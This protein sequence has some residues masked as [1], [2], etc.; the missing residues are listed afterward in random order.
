MTEGGMRYLY[1]AINLACCTVLAVAFN[2]WS[3]IF[4]SIFFWSFKDGKHV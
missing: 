1:N 2:R 3:L 4:L